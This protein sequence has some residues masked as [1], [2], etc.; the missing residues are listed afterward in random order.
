MGGMLDMLEENEVRFIYEDDNV[1]VTFQDVGSEEYV[2]IHV[3]VKV[4]FTKALY[5]EWLLLFQDIRTVAHNMGYSTLM[6]AH[7]E[8]DTKKVK[9]WRMFGFD[10]REHG[11]GIV[12]F[13]PTE[14][15]W[16]I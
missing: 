4:R 14:V 6:A 5:E 1:Y 15:L 10:V 3:E 8:H 7:D 13:I 12:A 11:T 2:V 16:L 9:F